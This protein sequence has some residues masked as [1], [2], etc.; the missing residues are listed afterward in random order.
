[1]YLESQTPKTYKNI[2]WI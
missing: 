2:Y 1:M